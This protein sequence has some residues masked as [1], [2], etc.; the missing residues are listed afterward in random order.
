MHANRTYDILLLLLQRRTHTLR[1][2]AR[3]NDNNHKLQ[4]FSLHGTFKCVHACNKMNL[5]FKYI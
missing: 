5:S 1:I 4:L 2:T 3:N